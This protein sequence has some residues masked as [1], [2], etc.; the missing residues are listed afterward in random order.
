MTFP[1]PDFIPLR[2]DLLIGRLGPL[3]IFPP[4]R[5]RRK[6]RSTHT[7]VLGITGQGKSKL[8]EHLLYQDITAGRGAGLLDPHTDLAQDL[9]ALL[10]NTGYLKSERNRK[11]IIYFDPSRTDLIL[12]FN[13][14][15]TSYTPYATAINL[16]EAFRRTWSD[17]LKEAPRF[18]NILLASLLTLIANRQTLVQLPRLLTDRDF[19]ENL[20]GHVTDPEIVSVFHDRLEKWGREQPL[21]LESILNK[22]SALTINPALRTILGQQ[23]NRLDFRAIMDEGKVL[24]ADLGRCD[25]ETRR[26]LGSLITTGIEQAALSRKDA[27]SRKRRPFYFYIDEF[28]DFV[29]NEGSTTTLAQILSEARKFG[30]SLTLAHQTL[31]QVSERMTSAL[32][33]IGTKIVFAVDRTDA[34]TMAKK[35]FLISGEEVKHTVES[36]PHQDKTH[37]VFY[38]LWEEWEKATQAIQNLKPRTALIKVQQKGVA[39]IHTTAIKGDHLSVEQIERLE[40]RLMQQVGKAMGKDGINESMN[41]RAEHKPVFF[42]PVGKTRVQLTSAFS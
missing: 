5:L 2:D 3:P 6:K 26:L 18:S 42:E 15:S 41:K 4:F 35:L 38:T 30:L 21:I 40:R 32:G 17:S 28:Q 29:S 14:L 36:E 7:Y 11:R 39:K 9:L 22:I 10:Y 19:R 27:P 24:I 31:G 13:V 8:L 12:P 23:E 20:L 16:V 37:P 25:S 34:E 1:L 33:N